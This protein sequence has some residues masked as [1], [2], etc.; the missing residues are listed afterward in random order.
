MIVYISMM[1]SYIFMIFM[2]FIDFSCFL[3]Q[4]QQMLILDMKEWSRSLDIFFQ[5]FEKFEIW[6]ISKNSGRKNFSVRTEKQF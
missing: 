2:I 5:D 6:K 3:P 4:N 1:F